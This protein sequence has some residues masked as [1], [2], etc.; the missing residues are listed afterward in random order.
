M[1]NALLPYDLLTKVNHKSL[2]RADVELSQTVHIQSKSNRNQMVVGSNP[3]INLD[4]TKAEIM[5][6]FPT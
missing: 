3:V 6:N 1:P 2:N 5:K 4:I